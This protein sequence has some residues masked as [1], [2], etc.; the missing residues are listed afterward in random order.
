MF[1]AGIASSGRPAGA[2]CSEARGPVA[3]GVSVE[4][5]ERLDARLAELARG[6][7]RVRLTLGELLEALASRGG[8]HELGYSSLEAYARERVGQSGRWA[9][10]SRTLARRLAERPLLRA[11]LASGAL[12]WCMTELVARHAEPETEAGL[13]ALALRSTVRQMREH[14]EQ[15][16]PDRDEGE[17]E[18]CTLTLTLSQRDAWLFGWTRRFAAHVTGTRDSDAQLG[19]LLA[20]T[21]NTLCGVV[22]SN[23]VA[24]EAEADAARERVWRAELARWRHESERRC[25]ANFAARGPGGQGAVVSP[26]PVLGARD[27]D[28][29]IAALAAELAAQEVELAR[30]A[31]AFHRAEGPRHLGYSTE[32]QYARERLGLSASSFRAKLTLARRLS[33]PVRRALERGE[34]GLEAALAIGRVA[35]SETAADWVVRARERTVKHLLEDVRAAE[36]WRD[37]GG[38]AT[39][40]TPEAVRELHALEGRLLAGDRDVLLEPGSQMSA[41]SA[42]RVGGVRVRLRVSRDTARFFRGLEAALGRH[43]PRSV[44]FTE[45]LCV[46]FWD[47][48]K[49]LCQRD[50]AYARIY[51]R[52]RY[53]CSSPVCSRHDVTPHHVRFRALGGGDEDAN[54]TALCT[55]CHLE[56]VHGGRIEVTGQVGALTWQLGGLRVVGREKRRASVARSLALP[57]C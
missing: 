26:L 9:V 42:A 22:P 16:E 1:P 14:F 4:A 47:A 35:T 13:V 52:D 18:T 10:E 32:A 7:G 11:A 44:S 3:G 49:H 53:T 19:A 21:F 23:D 40:P 54:V 6:S 25:E 27:L 5:V 36:L 30:A 41:C 24:A 8:H 48:W 28:A 31:L 51:A 38:R 12:G 20:E 46:L 57:S 37:L 55:W 15:S 56:G 43:L 39:P 2:A 34:V 50:E 29:R 33:A 45:L 17:P